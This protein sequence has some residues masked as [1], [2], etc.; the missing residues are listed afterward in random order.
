MAGA[1][2]RPKTKAAMA[3]RGEKNIKGTK[4]RL[5]RDD[6]QRCDPPNSPPTA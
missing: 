6:D 3:R 4:M 2:D 5:V 1:V